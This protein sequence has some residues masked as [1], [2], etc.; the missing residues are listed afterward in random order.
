MAYLT[1]PKRALWPM[2]YGAFS[3]CLIFS[4]L[5]AKAGIEDVKE[6][7]C[8]LELDLSQQDEVDEVGEVDEVESYG[9]RPWEID[10]MNKVDEGEVSEVYLEAGQG[11]VTARVQQDG[12]ADDSPVSLSTL[13]G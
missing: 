10:D 9:E 8:I 4:P 11:D 13:K 3:Q 12:L 5:F 2:L 7:V 1:R 6:E